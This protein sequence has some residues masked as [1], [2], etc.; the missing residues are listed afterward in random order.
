M[1]KV[2]KFVEKGSAKKGERLHTSG[3][4]KHKTIQLVNVFLEVYSFPLL[5]Y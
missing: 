4:D 3:D 1:K 5:L 2:D